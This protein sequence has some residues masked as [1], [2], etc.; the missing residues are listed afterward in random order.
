[1]NRDVYVG[2]LGAI[3]AMGAGK[4]AQLK[5]LI[6]GE[7]A[8][9]PLT[10]FD[11]SHDVIVGEVKHSNRELAVMAG[12]KQEREYSRTTLLG[13]LAAAEALEDS[14][15]NIK[16]LRVGFISATSV[17]GMDISENFYSHYNKDSNRGRLRQ[18]IGHDCGASTQ[19]I[20]ERLR[21][22]SFVTTINTACSSA[23][24]AIMMGARMIKAGLLD[25]VI[26]GGTD[27]LCRFTI[28]GFSSLGILDREQCRPFDATRSGLN[29]GEGAGYLFLHSARVKT[30]RQY[31]TVAGYANANDAFH[32]TA[33]SADGAGSYLAMSGA[34]NMSGLRVKD[35]GYIN[36][37]GTGTPNNDASEGVAMNR[38]FAGNTPPFSSTKGF[39]GHTLGAAGGVESL[40]A[41]LSLTQ[42]YLWPNLNFRES[43][44][45]VPG[46]VP[47]TKTTKKEGITSVLTNSFGFGGNCSSIIFKQDKIGQL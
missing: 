20:A 13:L 22:E 15:V 30:H 34:L 21:T 9:G 46:M 36:V 40:F 25:A 3:T 42:G 5:G 44:C 23:N 7:T 38:L 43:I 16:G 37:H 11:T 28:N 24:N 45:E 1:M 18:L 14:G 26:A 6:S 39:T 8:L 33:S 27:S 4:A 17:G 32:Q 47:I 2:G 29:L 10:L 31:C 41:I 19:F 12:L 35:I